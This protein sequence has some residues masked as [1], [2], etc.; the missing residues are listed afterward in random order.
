MRTK[1]LGLF[2]A[3]VPVSVAAAQPVSYSSHVAPILAMNC[4]ACHG[5]NPDSAAGGLSTRTWADLSKG[6]NL[7]P[8]IVP[9]VPE[10]SAL[11]Q[12]VSGARGEAHRMPLGGPPIT[13]AQIDLIRQWIL[14]GAV[15]DSGITPKYR[16]DLPSLR[17]DRLSPVRISARIPSAAYVELELADPRE[18]TLYREGGAV[19]A[20][21]DSAAIG[22]PGEWITWNL[23]RASDWPER[24][25]ARLTVS[26][27]ASEPANAVV[28]ATGAIS[29]PEFPAGDAE[30]RILSSP[31]EKL[32]L[33]R[34]E[35][36]TGGLP[37]PG[38]WKTELEPGLY[39]LHL[40]HTQ[41]RAQAAVLFRVG[42][43][44][45]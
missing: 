38:R 41:R 20:A 43:A 33:H 32:M 29:G 31:D 40:Y 24:V 25:R 36:T 26:H 13:T 39:V 37:E 15:E 27:A 34:R 3:F 7:G 17:L 14:A 2:T 1:L 44:A 8:A 45:R 28:A 42:A 22:V 23:R 4:H 9:G 21:R 10:R 6:G 18:R 12:F 35:Q 11:Y 5:A 16:L 19:K 30:L